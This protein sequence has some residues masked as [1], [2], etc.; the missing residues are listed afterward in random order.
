[1]S[2]FRL[3]LQIEMGK[4]RLVELAKKHGRDNPKVL[5]ESQRLDRLIVELMRRKAS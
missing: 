1:M 2:V 3:H 4:L 5:K